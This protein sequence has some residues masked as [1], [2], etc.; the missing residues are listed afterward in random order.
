MRSARAANRWG[1]TLASQL[2]VQDVVT[3]RAAGVER[4]AGDGDRAARAVRAVHRDDRASVAGEL[5]RRAGLAGVSG[6]RVRGD[7]AA[8]IDAGDEGIGVL[9]LVC[10]QA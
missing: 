3:E 10:W 1:E 4:A 9:D 6:D 2:E 5:E 7:R 8:A